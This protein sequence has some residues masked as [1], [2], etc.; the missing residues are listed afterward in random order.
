MRALN[1]SLSM[2]PCR[3]ILTGGAQWET[4]LFKHLNVVLSQYIFG[5]VYCNN[6]AERLRRNFRMTGSATSPQYHL[7]ISVPEKVTRSVLAPIFLKILAVPLPDLFRSTTAWWKRFLGRRHTSCLPSANLRLNWDSSVNIPFFH[8]LFD[9][10]CYTASQFTLS[11]RWQCISCILAWNLLP[12]RRTTYSK[13]SK[14]S[15]VR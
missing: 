9:Q 11:W 5:V 7:E 14:L 10:R 12:W 6:V 3:R 8:R 2:S 13:Y 1:L 4:D 15:L